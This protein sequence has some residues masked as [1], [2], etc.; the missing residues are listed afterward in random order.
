MRRRSS[1]GAEELDP[2]DTSLLAIRRGRHGPAEVDFW[3]KLESKAAEVDSRSRREFPFTHQE[4]KEGQLLGDTETWREAMA[5]AN[6]VPTT[7]SPTKAMTAGPMAELAGGGVPKA[8]THPQKQYA[9]GWR[10]QDDQPNAAA[11]NA[12]SKK[13]LKIKKGGVQNKCWI[14]TSFGPDHREPPP[15]HHI[16]LSWEDT[17][18]G[19]GAKSFIEGYSNVTHRAFTTTKSDTCFELAERMLEQK[20]IYDNYYDPALKKIKTEAGDSEDGGNEGEA[21]GA[22]STSLFADS[23]GSGSDHEEM[24]REYRLPGLESNDQYYQRGGETGMRP[25]KGEAENQMKE[26]EGGAVAAAPFMPRI[27]SFAL[28]TKAD[29]SSAQIAGASES[30]MAEQQGTQQGPDL[31]GQTPRDADAGMRVKCEDVSAAARVVL[32]GEKCLLCN[33]GIDPKEAPYTVICTADRCL[34]HADCAANTLSLGSAL[35]VACNCNQDGE[36]KP[37]IIFANVHIATKAQSDARAEEKLKALQAKYEVEMLNSSSL[38]QKAMGAVKALTALTG[39]PDKEI[40]A[41]VL[42]I[43]HLISPGEE[44][45]LNAT[46]GNFVSKY[47]TGPEGL[48]SQ[49]PTRNFLQTLGVSE[50]QIKEAVMYQWLSQG[51]SGGWGKRRLYVAISSPQVALV[52][53]SAFAPRPGQATAGLS[54]LQQDKTSVFNPLKIKIATDPA[55]WEQP[56]II[57]TV[58]GEDMKIVFVP[59]KVGSTLEETLRCFKVSGYNEMLLDSSFQAPEPTYSSGKG[60]APE[61]K[62]VRHEPGSSP[63]WQ[64][65]T[66]RGGPGGSAGGYREGLGFR[67]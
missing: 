1:R 66:T 13:K 23:A 60:K 8:Q 21:P 19:A 28:A 65:S 35:T 50:I 15:T 40:S 38:L 49:A 22:K 61:Q 29:S 41:T 33:I 53:L 14:I 10:L 46:A 58:E 20:G 4:L 24:D 54:S 59:D 37:G 12:K 26:G 55:S 52:I 51:T 34:Y 25:H 32:G 9:P 39:P 18:D 44:A 27:P 48:L 7:P 56:K 67:V 36:T 3:S 47:I 45:K 30:A 63:H 2:Q 6:G 42:A 17:S 16:F 64:T 11:A 57:W 62:T 31:G 5:W 43:D